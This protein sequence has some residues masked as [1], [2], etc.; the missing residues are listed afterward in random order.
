MRKFLPVLL[1]LISAFPSSAFTDMEF[2][3]E[4]RQNEK[5]AKTRIL[6]IGKDPDHPYGSHR[7]MHTCGVLAK[8]VELTSGVEAIVSKGWPKDKKDVTDLKAIVVYT[9]PAAE[10][11][12]DSP[13]RDVI[14]AAFKSGVGLTTIHWASTVKKENYDRLSPV[15]LRYTGGTWISN[16]GLSDGPSLVKQLLPDHPISRGWKEFELNDEYY[17]NPVLKGARPLLQ[18]REKKGQDV[19]V[20]WVYERPDTSRAFATTL[21]HSYKYFQNGAFRRMVV[22]GILWSAKVEVPADGAPVNVGEQVLML[23]PPPKK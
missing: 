20:G 17:L 21:G 7:Y 18:V 6:F 23:P 14:E 5:A 10:F 3:A 8:C 13:D 11:L 15:W 16:V 9:N 2:V 19:I 22:N 1:C 4:P 12:L